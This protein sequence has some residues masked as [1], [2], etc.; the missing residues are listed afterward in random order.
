M[1]L[2]T[3]RNCGNL[4][5]LA[6][7][8]HLFRDD[9]PFVKLRNKGLLQS[10]KLPSAGH[11]VFANEVLMVNGVGSC[12]YCYA[13]GLCQDEKLTGNHGRRGIGSGIQLCLRD[14]VDIAG[15]I[16]V[17]IDMLGIRIILDMK[18]VGPNPGPTIGCYKCIMFSC[19]CHS[20]FCAY[21]FPEF[22][23]KIPTR[24]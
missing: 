20:L 1:G 12:R 18:I 22:S 9:V 23:H 21:F 3:V 16:H 2:C 17:D 8:D 15:L 13:T 14:T 24:Y 6:D 5:V 11:L 4:C 10:R 7:I 19:T